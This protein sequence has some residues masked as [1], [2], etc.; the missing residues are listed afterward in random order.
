MLYTIR[1]GTRLGHLH[2]KA[3]AHV[4]AHVCSCDVKQLQHGLQQVL[5]KLAGL[6]EAGQLVKGTAFESK[7]C[8]QGEEP[9]DM[10]HIGAKPY[11]PWLY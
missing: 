7:D 5:V 3:C 11:K 9:V 1:P 10:L 6:H 8:I 4:C 2:V